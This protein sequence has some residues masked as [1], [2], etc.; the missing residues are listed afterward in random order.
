MLRLSSAYLFLSLTINL[1]GQGFDCD[2]SIFIVTYTESTGV[3]VLYEVQERNQSFSYTAIELSED[4]RL[5]SLAYNV[6]DKHLYALDVDTYELIKINRNGRMTSLD[7]PA[8]LDKN[9]IYNAGTI[10]PNGSG[11]YLMGYSPE[12]GFD[13]KFYTI[14][15]SREDFYAGFLGVTGEARSEIH[16]FAT[17]PTSGEIYGYDNLEGSLGQ[18]AVG[19]LVSTTGFPNSGVSNIDGLFFNQEGDLFGYA[20]TKGFYA[21]NKLS[22]V[23][24]FVGSGPGGTSGDACSCPYT[25]T[26]EKEVQPREILPCEEFEITYS[27]NNRL[28]IGQTW[29]S[30]R[31]TLPEGFEIID[32]KSKIVTSVNIIE[33]PSNIIALDNLIYLMRD[34]EIKVTVRAPVDYIGPFGSKATHW[35]F[36][37]AFGEYQT[38]DDSSTDKEEDET[39]AMIVGQEELDFNDFIEYSCDGQEVTITSPIAS[40][41]YLWSNGSTEE[42]ITTNQEGWYSL[43]TQ[44][45]CVYFHDSVFISEF[46]NEKKLSLDGPDKT[47]IGSPI[48]LTSG[49][50]RGVPMLYKWYDGSDTIS[51]S[52]CYSMIFTPIEDT[53]YELYLIDDQGCQTD[54]TLEISV[55]IQRD[56]Y[57]ATAF[58]PNNDGIN[59]MFFL[60]SALQGTIKKMSVY[61]RWGGEV[62]SIQDVPLNESEQGWDGTLSNKEAS[63]TGVFIWVAEIEYLDGFIESKTGTV[64]LITQ[65]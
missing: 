49:V 62:F 54:A 15:L 51:C 34:N 9:F 43:I 7:V 12:F 10:S 61:N 50:N 18:I 24:K 25:S 35:D 38:S 46:L 13:K 60:Q 55:D 45:D 29:V 11:I 16:D 4:R 17:D 53:V 31:D 27:Y 33:S 3:S 42:S 32:I 23:L 30:L 19:G 57:A 37:F 65:N 56:F 44:N 63:A 64:T 48:R 39:M 20:A 58:S 21:I 40:E 47:K 2:G 26:F 6:L 41:D 22:G 14:N 59:D 1:L 28:G 52:D 5:T 36:P 8:S